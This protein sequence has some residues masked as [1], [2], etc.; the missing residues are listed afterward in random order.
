MTNRTG[1][2]PVSGG[3][4]LYYEVGGAGP[5]VVL[6]HA[7]SW[8]A[9]M[10]EPQFEAF[11]T[12]GHTV[13]RYDQRGYGRSSRFDA[14][15]SPVGDHADL[16]EHLGLPSA[17]MVGISRGGRLAIDTAIERPEL[18]DALVVACSALSGYRWDAGPEIEAKLE[19]MERLAEGGELERA[20]ELEL[21]V[22]TPLSTD[23]STDR[24]IH[25]VAMDNRHV[26]MLDWSLAEQLSPPA[27]ERLGQVRARALVMAA[28]HDVGAFQALADVIAAGI[29]SARKVVIEGADHLPNLRKPDAFNRLV[30]EFL[31][32]G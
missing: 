26:A 30:L 12:A 21:S 23:P 29:P 27:A 14:P 15:Y 3:G 9:R 11:V 1:L 2:A 19:E 8:D 24:L 10:W 13:V 18:V 25:D 7:G 5:P 28:D 22:W 6:L 31:A 32:D 20:A 17:A 4:A 16:L